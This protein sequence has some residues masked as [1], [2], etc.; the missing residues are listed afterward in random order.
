MLVI[1]HLGIVILYLEVHVYNMRGIRA[2]VVL[3]FC[4]GLCLPGCLSFGEDSNT[5]EL[6]VNYNTLNGTVIESYLDGELTSLESFEFIVDFSETKS[7]TK[8]KKFGIEFDDDR[9]PI[10][11][12][13]QDETSIIVSFSEHGMYNL[14]A[15]AIDEQNNRASTTEKIRVDLRINWIEDD[16]NEPEK[17]PFNPIPSNSGEHPIYIEIVSTVENPSI[18]EDFGGG[19]SVDFTWKIT[20]EL[21]DTCQSYS[22]QVGDGESVTWNTIHFNTYLLH[23]LSIEYDE[24]Q[25]YISV[26]HTVSIIYESE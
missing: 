2:V 15:Y 16:T 6:Q 24:G 21:G 8:L 22:E 10:E 14:T 5:I 3:I 7:E 20:D 9:E 12:E 18:I 4:S 26:S 1:V 17:M 11:V 25:D 23:D 19:R 13:F